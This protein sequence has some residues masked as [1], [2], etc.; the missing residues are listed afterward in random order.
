MALLYV[1]DDELIRSTTAARLR[2]RG[3]TV[4]E[5]ASGEIALGLADGE[6]LECVV[7]DLDLPGID[8]LETFER[9]IAGWPSLR[10]VVCSA[11]L[12]P[13]I[14]R[15]FLELGVPAACLLTKPCSFARLLA[16]IEVTAAEE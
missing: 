3:Y 12:T 15:R 2:R 6:P 11:L 7:L 4:L 13:T 8:G 10:A 9:L 5:A 1:E 16:A 14:R